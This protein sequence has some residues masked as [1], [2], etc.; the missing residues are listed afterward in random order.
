[1]APD[2]VLH[3][4]IYTGLKADL[5]CGRY[6][7]GEHIDLQAISDSHRASVTPVRE[8][9]CRL[10]GEGLA[11]FQRHGGFRFAE[12]D[13]EEL[14]SLYALNSTLLIGAIRQSANE[15]LDE[16]VGSIVFPGSDAHTEEIVISTAAV[17]AVLASAGGN[18]NFLR[19]V[20]NISDRLSFARRIESVLLKDVRSELLML[21][22]G[23]VG[24]LKR[25]LGRRITMYHRRRMAVADEIIRRIN[26]E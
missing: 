24:H 2:P 9:V 10:V 3:E 20:E 6:T 11:T 21:N 25:T 12:L 18:G 16:A 5:L 14:C 1:M 17:F 13:V 15:A 23:P 22:H 7:P 4:R 26:N 8:V 19:C